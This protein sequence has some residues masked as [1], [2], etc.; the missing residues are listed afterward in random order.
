[1]KKIILVFSQ[2]TWPLSRCIANLKTLAH[3][4]AEKSVTEI[5]I[6]EKENGT[7]NGYDKQEE[8]D[9]LLRN[10]TSHT[11]HCIKFQNP[12]CSCS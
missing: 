12:R 6:G 2:H 7:N 4:E 1:M 9:S 3:I 10:S 11:Q 8:A 5:L